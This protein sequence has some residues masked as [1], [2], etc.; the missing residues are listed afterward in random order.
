[1]TSEKQKITDFNNPDYYDN[2]E[3]SWLSFNQRVLAEAEDSRNPLLERLGFISI[4]ASNLDE[5][6]MVRV[7]G[8]QDQ[9]HW[10]V[11]TRDSKKQWTPAQQLQAIAEVNHKLVDYQYG[12]YHDLV[13][14]CQDRGIYFQGVDQLSDQVLDQLKLESFN[15]IYPALT[16]LGIDAY[17]PFPNLNNKVINLFVRLKKAGQ[18]EKLAIVP[19]PQLM[20]RFHT[21]QHDGNHYLVYTEEIIRHFIGEL[22]QGY[23]V[24]S[25]FFFRITRN[26]DLD[27]QEEG[28]Q[29]LLAVIE[30]YLIKRRQGMAVRIEI[31]QRFINPDTD[32]A[33]IDFLL[34]SLELTD[35]DLY[36]VDGPP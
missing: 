8:L 10:Q 6:M 17:R 30:D 18:E 25:A 5:F 21:C 34:D 31:D 3:I 9:D 22:F 19:L 16:P 33:D 32:Q 20:K 2:R 15:D 4:G 11:K 28:A 24:K 26:A 12:L 1:M 36:L 7:A 27:I 14:L 35:Q 29:D 23:Q 13:A